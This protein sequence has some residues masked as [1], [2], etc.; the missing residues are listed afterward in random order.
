MDFRERRP[1]PRFGRADA[2]LVTAARP[3]SG[4]SLSNRV[5]V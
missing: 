4:L 5:N 1:P 2:I 3:T